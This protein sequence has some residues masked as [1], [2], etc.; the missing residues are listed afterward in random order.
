MFIV[1]ETQTNADKT[2]GMIPVAFEDENQAK[3]KYHQILSVA[4]ISNVPVHAAF[5][6]RDD[7]YMM[8][9]ES[10]RHEEESNEG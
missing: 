9:S 2:V 6:V 8:I 10:F 3:A 7:G 4:A 5:L 1:I